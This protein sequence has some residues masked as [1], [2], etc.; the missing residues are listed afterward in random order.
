MAYPASGAMSAQPYPA[1]L[2]GLFKRLANRTHAVLVTGI[3]AP[4]LQ[5]DVMR[6]AAA[7]VVVFEPTLPSI[8]AA[9]RSMTRVGVEHPVTLVQCSTRMRRYT[10]SPAHVRYAFAERSPDA[11]IP[12]DPAL[13]ATAT[14]R[15]S[16]ARPRK[17]YR[18]ALQR[19]I[20]LVGAARHA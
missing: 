19:A 10:L 15:K 4:E 3:A 12:F 20:E 6:Q 17:A 7:R 18:K 11:V 8:D 2:F 14:G 1:A 13:H 16:Q 9:V 5:I